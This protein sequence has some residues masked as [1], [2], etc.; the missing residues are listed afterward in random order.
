MWASYGMALPLSFWDYLG[1]GGLLLCSSL[2]SGL[3]G[4]QSD[5]P[6]LATAWSSPQPGSLSPILRNFG[7]TW[8]TSY[9]GIWSAL[10][11]LLPPQAEGGLAMGLPASHPPPPLLHFLPGWSPWS[12]RWQPRAPPPLPQT[13]CHPTLTSSSVPPGL[14]P[15]F[16]RRTPTPP[17]PYWIPH[18]LGSSAHLPAHVDGLPALPGR[19]KPA[20]RPLRGLLS[21]APKL[22]QGAPLLPLLHTCPNPPQL[23]TDPQLDHPA[24]FPMACPCSAPSAD[25]CLRFFSDCSSEEANHK[26]KI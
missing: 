21:L 26:S 2:G 17:P 13:C 15:R 6:G 10:S 7:T 19:G 11:S 1:F 22:D 25:R 20:H 9:L 24:I 4:D 18:P 5:S 14:P 8:D 12:S 16:S 3:F 23:S